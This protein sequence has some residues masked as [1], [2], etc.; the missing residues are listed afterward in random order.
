MALDER[1]LVSV[2]VP[3]Y[4]VERYLDCCL[5]S[6]RT[7]T[8]GRLEIIVVE[9]GSTDG[10]MARLEPHLADPRLRL[11]R[12]ERN[13][14]L[15]A[16]RNTGIE[17]A[18]GDFVL[19]VDS[20][21]AI[22]SALVESCLVQAT[23]AG[24]DMVVFDFVAFQDGEKLPTVGQTAGTT[25]SRRLERADYLEL[26]HFVWL[27]FI[28]AEL[29]RDQTLRFP[30]G[31]YY[32][33]WPF[34][35][36]L[37]FSAESI[38]MLDGRWYCYRQ[39][40]TSITGSMGRILLDQL[41]VQQIVLDTVRRRGG[42]TEAN[43]LFAKA[44]ATFWAV[45]TRIDADLLPEAVAAAREL[46]SGLQSLSPSRPQGVRAMAVS[47]LLSLPGPLAGAGVHVLRGA[48]GIFSATAGVRNLV[49]TRNGG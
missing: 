6:I 18:N 7:Q 2:I 31:Y 45:L 34:H 40:S 29:L 38:T 48:K 22:A 46:R 23:G 4:N 25:N 11:I 10:S 47:L 33:D 36:G 27:K 14:G 3:V 44:H 12:H 19:F 37:G 13:S 20:D 17:A 21:D 9:D 42:R 41:R 39:R 5:D 26:P 43:L 16:A 8:Y 15:S 30:V 49:G 24:A 32:E 1:P 28:R 35:W